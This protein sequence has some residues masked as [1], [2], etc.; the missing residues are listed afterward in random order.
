MGCLVGWGLEVSAGAGTPTQPVRPSV[1]LG[2]QR[3]VEVLQLSGSV[4]HTYRVL[5]PGV[6]RWGVQRGERATRRPGRSAQQQRQHA[7]QKAAG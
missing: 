7:G 5:Q 1:G 3:A 4:G 6:Q 2:S